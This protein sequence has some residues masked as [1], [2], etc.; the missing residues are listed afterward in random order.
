MTIRFK[1]GYT[2]EYPDGHPYYQGAWSEDRFRLQHNP[3]AGPG[4]IQR[5]LEKLKDQKINLGVALAEAKQ[6]AELIA[7]TANKIARQVQQIQRRSPKDWARAAASGWRKIPQSYLEASYGWVP[8]MSDVDGACQHL[9]DSVLRGLRPQLTA[10]GRHRLV[11][12]PLLPERAGTLLQQWKVD[13][14]TL[15]QCTVCCDVPDW[16][17]QEY[18]QLGLT[19]PL[20]IVWEKVPW[21][22]VA[23]WFLPLGDWINTF[24]VGNYLSFKEGSLSLITRGSGSPVSIV[25]NNPY[26]KE[27]DENTSRAPRVKAWEF[28]RSV[29]LQMPR[30]SF[31][32]LRNPLSLDKTAKALALL[33]QVFR[34]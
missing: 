30:L 4:A 21:S 15:A 25:V 28:N 9:A 3:D 29:L 7:G 17:L 1:D 11:G 27:F 33:T 26:V 10:V 16:V 34:R 5:C 18:S 13:V 22:F 6:T 19:N 2:E 14:S 12:D 20:S 32:S 24:D 8:L 31:P 23:D